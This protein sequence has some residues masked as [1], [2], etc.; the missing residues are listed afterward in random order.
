MTFHLIVIFII[1][2]FVLVKAGSGAVKCL[3]KIAK[4]LKWTEFTTAFLLMAFITSLP[5]LFV[6]ITSALHGNPEISLGNVFGSNI[7]NLTLAVAIAVLIAGA[8]KAKT[9]LAQKTSIYSAVIAV[10]PILLMVDGVL[11]RIDGVI[12]ILLLCFY[13]WSVARKKDL[14]KERGIQKDFAWNKSFVKAVIFFF[15]YV[16]LLL[17]GAEG[18][19]WSSTEMAMSFNIP[20]LLIG[21]IL[22]A[23]GTNLPE[24]IFSVK[25]ASSGHKDMILGNLMGSVIANSTLV[26][27]VTVLINPIRIFTFTPFI[28]GMIFIVLTVIF[29]AIF[30]RTERQVTKKEAIILLL[31]YV[32]FI[33][34]QI[35][36]H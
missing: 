35:I 16:L 34:T 30:V 33:V 1:S 12:M 21:I 18:V 28:A 24:I 17:L 32:L 10:V 9:A 8:L 2:V 7:I 3:A 6:G 36:I 25:A 5:E 29:F 22:V 20:L 4:S 27:G 13:L 19:V 31:V 23:L 26:L 15:L 11:N 14:S